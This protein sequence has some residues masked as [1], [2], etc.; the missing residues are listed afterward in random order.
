MALSIVRPP[1]G[2]RGAAAEATPAAIRI[3]ILDPGAV[4]AAEM[5]AFLAA[6]GFSPRC[7]ANTA[8]LLRD[9]AEARLDLILLD[10]KL[11]AES[12]LDAIRRIRAVSAIPCMV[13]AAGTSEL[14]RVVSLE[15]GADHYLSKDLSFR[16][17]LA[18]IRA[19]LRRAPPATTLRTGIG[20]W[21]VLPAQRDVLRPDGLPCGLTSAEFDILFQLVT[22]AG[23]TVSR[24]D[25]CRQVFG[26]P[27]RVG[28]RTVDMLITRLRRKMEPNPDQPQM[29]KTVRPIGYCFG[30]FPTDFP[31]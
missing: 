6:E 29:I 23:Q 13:L 28:D 30:G 1:N 16:E 11:E 24:D 18:H 5:E 26:R 7:F 12:G 17:V 2:E 4:F 27:Y 22:A 9:L 10:L 20:G 25:I 14:D 3:A 19:L 21:R 15:L 31:E 8:T